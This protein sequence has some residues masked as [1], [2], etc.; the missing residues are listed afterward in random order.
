MK[1]GFLEMVRFE[2]NMALKFLFSLSFV[3]KGEGQKETFLKVKLSCRG[4]RC[5]QYVIAFDFIVVTRE[6]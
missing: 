2:L 3:G 5:S 1:C 6:G 4:K